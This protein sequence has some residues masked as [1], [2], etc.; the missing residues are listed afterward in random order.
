MCLFYAF[1]QRWQ[2]FWTLSIVYL[3][4]HPLSRGTCIQFLSKCVYF[5]LVPNDWHRLKRC[6]SFIWNYIHSHMA[7]VTCIQ[8]MP[9]CDYFYTFPLRWQSF[10]TLSIVYLELH[11]LSRGTWHMYSISVKMCLFLRFSLTI[12]SVL[13]DCQRRSYL[14]VARDKTL[15]IIKIKL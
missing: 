14:H 15:V 9:K 3:E 10:K 6:Q 4:L 2:P 13:N 12:D 5:T 11:P 1:P 7:R 8:F